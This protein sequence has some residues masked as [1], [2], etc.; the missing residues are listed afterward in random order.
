MGFDGYQLCFDTTKCWSKVICIDC[1]RVGIKWMSFDRNQMC[2]DRFKCVL[3][4]IEWVLIGFKWF[5]STS[6]RV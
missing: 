6:N 1:V 4:G 2:F 5:W 3:I